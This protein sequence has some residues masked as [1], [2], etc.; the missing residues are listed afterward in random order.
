M[1]FAFLRVLKT[2]WSLGRIYVLN[3]RASS[4]FC[5][6]S[7]E[8]LLESPVPKSHSPCPPNFSALTFGRPG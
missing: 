7:S 1:T 8:S 2:V 6:R 3:G 4:T 5:I